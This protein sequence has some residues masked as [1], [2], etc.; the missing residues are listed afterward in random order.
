M[1]VLF[2]IV[3]PL[4]SICAKNANEFR[5]TI[6]EKS[7]IRMLESNTGRSLAVQ[8]RFHCGCE[9]GPTRC[10]LVDSARLAVRLIKEQGSNHIRICLEA[11]KLSEILETFGSMREKLK[12]SE[13]ILLEALRLRSLHK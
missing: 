10:S 7:I 13:I 3:Y 4:V 8:P 2:T 5:G 1:S 12:L 9:N 11:V 6:W